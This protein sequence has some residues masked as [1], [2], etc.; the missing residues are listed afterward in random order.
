MA[1][2]I[3]QREIKFRT[4]SKYSYVLQEYTGLK[5]KHGKE[6]YEGDIVKRRFDKVSVV[7]FEKGSFLL[8][9]M[10]IGETDLLG[11]E[12]KDCEVIGNIYENKNLLKQN[13]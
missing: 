10:L 11:D 8:E 9:P 3:K 13:G 12:N 4:R 1:K 6:I 2:T 5:D 7:Y